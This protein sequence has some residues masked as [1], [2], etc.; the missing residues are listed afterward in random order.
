MLCLNYEG[1]L[2]V[3]QENLN[4]YQYLPEFD[5][6]HKCYTYTYT[7]TQHKTLVLFFPEEQSYQQTNIVVFQ[8]TFVSDLMCL[9][10]QCSKLKYTPNLDQQKEVSP[11][12]RSK[13]IQLYVK[14]SIL[15]SYLC[16]ITTSVLLSRISV[17]IVPRISRLNSISSACLRVRF[18]ALYNV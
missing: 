4:I 8:M 6:V 5:S 7:H 12:T 10:G 13:P 17:S 16:Q 18:A 15:Q 1:R 3:Y 11:M 2:L 9:A 14:V